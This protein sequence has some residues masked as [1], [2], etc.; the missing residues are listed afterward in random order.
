MHLHP[1]WGTGDKSDDK[2]EPVCVILKH[3]LF[4]LLVFLLSK[5]KYYMSKELEQNKLFMKKTPSSKPAHAD[6][7]KESSG[8]ADIFLFSTGYESSGWPDTGSCCHIVAR[9]MKL[10]S[11]L[12][13]WAHSCS[14]NETELRDHLNVSAPIESVVRQKNNCW[15]A[16]CS[17]A[18]WKTCGHATMK[19][20][21]RPC[22]PSMTSEFWNTT[23]VFGSMSA[24]I[25]SKGGRER[26]R[27]LRSY[28]ERN[29]R[30][31]WW[32]IQTTAHDAP[33][34]W[35]LVLNLPTL[36]WQQGVCWALKTLIKS[37]ANELWNPKIKKLKKNVK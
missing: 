7:M 11:L 10:D 22:L 1:T 27:S 21:C 14:V 17:T 23:N 6:S 36:V 24:E 15:R 2:H 32:A 19:L 4:E 28:A 31:R 5:L 12:K 18:W 34:W 26:P 20:V 3:M 25:W 37:W 13:W 30:G 29:L 8:K 35:L 16:E 9:R 33:C